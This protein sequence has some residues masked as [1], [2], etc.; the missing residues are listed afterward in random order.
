MTKVLDEWKKVTLQNYNIYA[1]DFDTFATTY[2]GKL[3]NWVEDFANQ[4]KKGARIL[5]VGC[6]SGRDAL[7]LSQKGLTITGI[8][9]SKEL[10]QIAREKVPQ[11]TFLVMDFEK[12]TFSNNSF[13]GIWANASLLHMPRKKLLPVLKKLY[14]ILVAG[15]YVFMQFRVGEGEKFTLER[16]GNAMLKR[17]YA[18]YS[19]DE[20]KNMLKQAG[21]RKLQYE[22]DTIISGDWVG[23]FAEK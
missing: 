20:L 13:D 10:I 23:L 5:D 19:C 16:R 2:R 3:K 8:D 21:F 18:Y 12:L 17:F 22:L 11:A 14:K 15:G 4:F 1:K 6:G 7:F 9:F